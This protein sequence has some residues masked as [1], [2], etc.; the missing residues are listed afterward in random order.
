MILGIDL[1]TNP[2]GG[3]LRHIIELLD[4]YDKKNNFNKVVIVASRKTLNNLNDYPWLIKKC[5]KMLQK[6][7]LIKAVWTLLYK[8]KEFNEVDI[9]FAPFGTYFSR[10]KKLVSMSQNMLLFDQNERSRFF[11]SLIWFKLTFLSFFQKLCFVNSNAIIFI[12]K[13]AQKSILPLFKNKNITST[14]IHH[15]ISHKFLKNPKIQ[16][17]IS[18][19]DENNKF[20]ILFVSSIWVYKHHLNLIAAFKILL[21]KGYPIEL[22]LVGDNAQRTIGKKIEQEIL[23]FEN[24]IRWH[25]NY[26]LNNINQIYFDSDLFVFTSTCENMPNILIESMISGLP[27]CSSNYEPMPEFLKDGGLYFD[28]LNVSDIALKIETLILDSNLRKELSQKSYK[29]SLQYSW[30]KCAQET[31][32]F[33]NQIALTHV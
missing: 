31:F 14:V 1:T 27:I 6:N 8:H 23:N 29:Y 33:L 25:K 18:N 12:S 5:P 28:P 30:R 16:Y 20:K 15:G 26:N 11:I 24:S 10:S 4:N 19:Y 32:N 3:G 13:Y 9:V 2:S 22:H 17:P 21:K 7:I